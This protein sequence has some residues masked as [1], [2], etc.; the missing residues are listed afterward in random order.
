MILALN[1]YISLRIA[2]KER[3]STFVNYCSF[4][5]YCRMVPLSVISTKKLKGKFKCQRIFSA[6]F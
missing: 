5:S 4:E 3:D 2:Q 6:I 1:I